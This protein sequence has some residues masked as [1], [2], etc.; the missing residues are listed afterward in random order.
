MRA[1]SSAAAAVLAGPTPVMAV[2]V[3]MA[4]SAPLRV[5]SWHRPLVWQGNTYLGAGELGQVDATDE[6]TE[7]PRPLRFSINGLPSASVSLVL[8]EPVQGRSVSLHV[9][10][11][12]PWTHQVLDA[13][14][15]WQ[16]VIDTMAITEDGSTA[17]VSVS[18]ESAGLD[19]LRAVPVRYT[20]IDQQRLYPGDL[21][22]QYVTD[23]A[24]KTIVWP[25]AEF[26]K[27]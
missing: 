14:L 10:I 22:L 8:S 24:E 25:K 15:E 11:F 12:D 9:A 21:F 27:Q 3:D 18:A 26:F 2:L 6:S 4:L 19:L 13:A 7:Q 23:Q 20:D 5:S 1:I 16:G 17:T